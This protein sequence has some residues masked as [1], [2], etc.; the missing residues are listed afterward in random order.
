MSTEINCFSQNV[1][2]PSFLGVD[3]VVQRIAQIHSLDFHI[4]RIESAIINYRLSCVQSFLGSQKTPKPQLGIPLKKVAVSFVLG[5]PDSNFS[6]CLLDSRSIPTCSPSRSAYNCD[7]GAS[8]SL[9]K[10]AGTPW[11]LGCLLGSSKVAKTSLNPMKNLVESD[12]DAP[13]TAHQTSCTWHPA[14]PGDEK[15]SWGWDLFLAMASTQ[16]FFGRGEFIPW[17]LY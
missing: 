4:A 9:Q 6:C 13:R 14:A 3:F 10:P 7:L 11:Q 16:V 5:I 17:I 2:F 12:G 8:F 15:R 1:H